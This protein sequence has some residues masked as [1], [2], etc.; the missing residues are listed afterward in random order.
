LAE[1]WDCENGPDCENRA[2]AGE[3]F[4]SVAE[5][6]AA[7][8]RN[9]TERAARLVRGSPTEAYRRLYLPD[10]PEPLNIVHVHGVLASCFDYR[11]V[12]CKLADAFRELRLGAGDGEAW[13]L[14][15][16]H[17]REYGALSVLLPGSDPQGQLFA[18]VSGCQELKMTPAAVVE[19]PRT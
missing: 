16:S 6:E 5:A 15:R 7:A 18:F 2:H 10:G 1:G 9:A 4:G 12:G 13:K 17:R 8:P 14:V 11:E 19:L 3:L